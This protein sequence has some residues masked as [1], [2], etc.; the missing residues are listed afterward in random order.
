M[1]YCFRPVSAWIVGLLTHREVSAGCAP[2]EGRA[3]SEGSSVRPSQRTSQRRAARCCAHETSPAAAQP[4]T[5]LLLRPLVLVEER[6]L[7]A[8]RQRLHG[9]HAMRSL[10]AQAAWAVI[11]QGWAHSLASAAIQACPLPPGPS[12]P[13]PPAAPTCTVAGPAARSRLS[14]ATAASRCRST[15]P[16]LHLAAAGGWGH[17]CGPAA[18]T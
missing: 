6:D 16:P 7:A 10:Q 3:A 12:G 4:P 5:K 18:L 14:T 15:L 2:S 11:L 8:R 17:P 1:L 13:A 9:G